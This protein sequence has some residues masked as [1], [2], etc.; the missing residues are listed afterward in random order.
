MLTLSFLIYSYHP[1]GGQQR[2]FLRVVEQCVQRGHKVNV[3]TMKWQGER[4]AGVNI[5][6]LPVSALFNHTL[7]RRFTALAHKALAENPADVVVGFNKMPGLDV[8][9][10]A[11]PCFA[12]RALNHR[13][14]YYRF[15]P[16][17]RHFMDYENAVFGASSKTRALILSPLQRQQF[18]KHYPGCEAR[19]Y[20]LPPGISKD[21]RAPANAAQIRAQLRQEFALNEQDYLVLHVGS[22]FVV[23]GVDRSLRAIASLPDEIRARTTCLV[24]GQD[25]PGRFRGLALGL[26]INDRVKF[27][28]G[29]DDVPRFLLAADLL[30]HPAYSESAGYVLLEATVAGLPVLTTDTCGYAFHIEQAGS[31]EVCASPFEQQDLDQRLLEML[32]SPRRLQWAENGLHYADTADLYSMP[33]TAASLIEQ[34]AAE[35]AGN[36]VSA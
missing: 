25:K 5:S 1:Y 20:D 3:Y 10:A 17:F 26:G 23:K 22:G 7:Y 15:T 35:G 16:R 12:E 18:S 13:G 6:V 34:F 21:R 29:R 14:S 30:L 31:G 28:G 19:L 2:D 32:I 24:V 11:D 4:P 9:F 36:A 27:L 8:Y 33:E